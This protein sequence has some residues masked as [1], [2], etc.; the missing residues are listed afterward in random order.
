LVTSIWSNNLTTGAFVKL[1]DTSTRVNGG[2]GKFVS[3][4]SCGNDANGPDFQLPG[5][6]LLF[7]GADSGAAG[8]EGGL[9]T[10]PVAGGR[11][12]KVA[13]YH[14]SLPGGGTFSAFQGLLSISLDRG[15]AVFSAQAAN[16][17]DTG[18]WS[19][20]ASGGGIERIADDNTLYC[21]DPPA[22]LDNAMYYS[23]DFIG[24]TEVAFIGGGG[25]GEF[26]SN[27]LFVTPVSSPVL[28][29]VLTKHYGLLRPAGSPYIN[30]NLGPANKLGRGK[31]TKATLE[32][33]GPAG[34]SIAFTSEL[35][36]PGA[37]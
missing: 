25:F 23:A 34:A 21:W 3:F 17:S 31:S 20:T 37:R 30:L 7:F 1:V 12:Y 28:N 24:G 29:P 32:F 11:V 16:P 13:D 8:C 19:A 4:A 6:T 10:L 2:T 15:R 22:C 18:I 35:A 5:G 36:G 14:T 27:G 26:G 33:K 9:Y